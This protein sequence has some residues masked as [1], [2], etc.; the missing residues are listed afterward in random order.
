MQRVNTVLLIGNGGR[1]HAWAIALKNSGAR[2][3]TWAPTLNPGIEDIAEITI[4]SDYEKDVD[5]L[6]EWI[7]D[8]DLAII[9]PEAPLVKGMTDWLQSLGIM[10]F[11]PTQANARLEGSKAY[12]RNLLSAHNIEGNIEYTVCTSEDELRSALEKNLSVVI[13]PDG[14]TGGK[15]VRV[16]GDHFTTVEEAFD[17]G[18][19]LIRSDGRVLLE[20]K[21]NGAEFSLQGL[22]YGD[23][24]VFL[25]LVKD[26]KRA[27]DGDTGPNTGSM[28]AVSYPGHG[29][30]YVTHGDLESAKSIVRDVLRALEKENG[31]YTGAIYGQFML[32]KDGPRVVEFNAR[33]G[34]PEAINT[35]A[36]LETPLLEVIE[37]LSKGTTPDVKF[38]ETA[39]CVVY[40]VPE[41]YP[42]NPLEG[43]R[44]ELPDEI[45]D[46]LRF[47]SVRKE[48]EHL[49]T[50][51][52]RS[53][54]VIG[55]GNTLK[56]A[57]DNAYNLIPDGISG[58]RFR[59]DIGRP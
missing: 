1:E 45:Y 51:R 31:K 8:I 6:S 14:L 58:L 35:L 5:L 21:L 28:G 57:V 3:I 7:E 46:S 52:S 49:Y 23:K 54:A 18:S 38:S 16:H 27:Y 10:V 30:P 39:T 17:Y 15:G 40:L 53:L 32:T 42:E 20:E 13:K 11:S 47:A 19:S 44:V 43:R 36:L 29:L 22:A 37:I 56:E 33:L 59:T 25:P 41:G 4:Q 24:V 48:G 34:D 12:L 26:Y 50:T 55:R 9:G 2:L